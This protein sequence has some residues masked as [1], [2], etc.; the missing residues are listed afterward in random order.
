MYAVS[1]KSVVVT[2][3]RRRS[4][5]WPCLR[6]GLVSECREQ[7]IFFAQCSNFWTNCTIFKRIE[8]RLCFVFVLL[9]ITCCGCSV[10]QAA[11]VHRAEAR[12]PVHHLSTVLRGLAPTLVPASLEVLPSTTPPPA[13]IGPAA[14]GPAAGP[15]PVI[16]EARRRR[17]GYE[18]Y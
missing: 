11:T 14:V 4:L 5:R 12:P 13:R 3:D 9:S 15:G 1:Y 6:H 10:C 17:R 2:K 7:F 8:V 18:R 16:A